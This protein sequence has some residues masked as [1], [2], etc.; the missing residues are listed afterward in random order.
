MQSLN[1]GSDNM[2]WVFFVLVV[3]VIGCTAAENTAD[4]TVQADAD[5]NVI[6]DSSLEDVEDLEIEE[7]DL[8]GLDEDLSLLDD[9]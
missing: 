4:K 8:E 6:D 9:L 7:E 2:K 1:K 5:D 3:F